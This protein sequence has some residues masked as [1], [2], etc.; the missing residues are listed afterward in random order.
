MPKDSTTCLSIL[1]IF[2][3]KRKN[4]VETGFAKSDF[5]EMTVPVFGFFIDCSKAGSC[6]A[7]V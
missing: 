4:G 5:A 1:M 7:S 2:L 6:P 3:L